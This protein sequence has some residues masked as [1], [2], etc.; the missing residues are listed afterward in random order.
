MA[1]GTGDFKYEHV[2]GWAKVPENFDLAE[3]VAVDTD[4]N[5]RVFVFNRGN[6]PVLI[7]EPDGTFVSCWGEGK[8]VQPHRVFIAPDDT[9]FLAEAQVHP[10]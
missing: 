9:V 3:V 2:E 7:F 5:D 8:F 1:F 10:E 4:S 6:H